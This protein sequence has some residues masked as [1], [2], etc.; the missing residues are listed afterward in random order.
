MQT[1]RLTQMVGVVALLTTALCHATPRPNIV[2]LFADDLG[3]G[4]VGYQ[5]LTEIPTPHIDSIAKNGVAFTCGYV[6][7]PVCGPS[8]AGLMTGRYQNRFGFEDNPGPF[9]QKQGVLVGT[10]LNQK[11]MA[12]R[13][14]TLGYVTGMVGKWH[15]GKDARIEPHN[16]GFDEWF[17][18]NNGAS[19]YFVRDNPKKML[20][21]NGKPVK[22]EHQYLTGAFGRE[23]VAFIERHKAEAFFLFV[24]FNA[25]HGPLQAIEEQKKRFSKI[26]NEKRRTT[27]AM[28]WSMDRNVG[29]ILAALREQGLEE[30]TLVFFLSDNGGKPGGNY[31]YNTPLRGEKGQLL[32][33][34]IRIPFCAQWKG[35]LP[36]G[37]RVDFPVISLD[38]LPTAL[39]AAGATIPDGLDGIDLVP[40]VLGKSPA[41][42]RIL[43]W[44]F[45]FQWAIRDAEWKLV[46]TKN[47]PEMLFR[48]AEDMCEKNDLI[49]IHPEVAARL[50]KTHEAW[51]A[52]L[53]KPQWGWQPAF[54]G[55]IRVEE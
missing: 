2:V 25:V 48:I 18:F 24:P 35:R 27:A 12:E 53:M 26:E 5:G 49:R 38:I 23:A 39:A 54:C 36:A 43:H 9:R 13:F 50:R 7:A 14:K 37:K 44:R 42:D 47:D 19:E 22:A 52:T 15:E 32:E 6:T 40:H 30:N 31:S 20:V 51:T 33:G 8:R 1:R 29:K 41:P 45:L 4:D 16:R 28:L 21:R 34:G 17:G 55:K 11:N 10:P 46:K 3:Y